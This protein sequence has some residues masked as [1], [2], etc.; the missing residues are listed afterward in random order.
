MQRLLLTLLLMSF[1]NT[2]M[3]TIKIY[4]EEMPA[5]TEM[6]A[7]AKAKQDEMMAK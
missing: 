7:D 6:S 1:L 2:G 4:A 3:L 5:A